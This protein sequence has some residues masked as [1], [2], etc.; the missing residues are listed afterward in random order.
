M[1]VA[2]FLKFHDTWVGIEMPHEKVQDA[3]DEN[4]AWW[5]SSGSWRDDPRYQAWLAGEEDDD[6]IDSYADGPQTY[7]VE[8]DPDDELVIDG[9]V[10]TDTL[11]EKGVPWSKDDLGR[12]LKMLAERADD[13]RPEWVRP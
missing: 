13:T 11:Q 5:E 8:D 9:E 7:R 1:M 4:D 6:W 10:I 2:K 12:A 3:W